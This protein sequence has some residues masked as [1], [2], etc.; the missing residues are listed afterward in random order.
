MPIKWFKI[1]ILH[2]IMA[3]SCDFWQFAAIIGNSMFCVVTS[4][5]QKIKPISQSSTKLWIAILNRMTQK[6]LSASFPVILIIS[7]QY[8]LNRESLVIVTENMLWTDRRM[9]GRTD[10]QDENIYA[11]SPFGGGIN[12]YFSQFVVKHGKYNHL[13]GVAIFFKMRYYKP[14]FG[15]I[16]NLCYS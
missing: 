3:I 2:K 6:S 13:K 15:E 8:Q 7:L 11:S 16:L 14:I 12:K 4:R 10:R 9:D 1:P 5:K